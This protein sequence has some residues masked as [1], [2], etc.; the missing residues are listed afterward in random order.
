MVSV[1]EIGDGTEVAR[2]AFSDESTRCA[3][4]P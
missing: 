2:F 1:I 3:A 4:N